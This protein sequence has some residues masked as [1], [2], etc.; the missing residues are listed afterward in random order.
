LAADVAPCDQPTTPVDPAD[1]AS[2]TFSLGD[3]W[4][5]SC[6]WLISANLQRMEGVHEAEVNFI[7]REAHV[8][9]DPSRVDPRR[10]LR[11]VRQLGYRAWLPGDKPYDEEEAHWFRLL[12]CSVLVMHDMLG[13]MTLY[14]RDWLGWSTPDQEWLVHIFNLMSLMASVPVILLLGIPILRAGIA[15]LLQRRAN[16]HA[17]I[18][19]GA[20]AAF[21]LS[22]RNIM[23]GHGRVY[24]DT[25]T[26]LLFL[27]AIGHWLEMRAQKQSNQAVERLFAELPQEATWI[28]AEGEQHLPLEQVSK[29]ARLRVRPGERF[30]VDGVVARGEGDVDESL[31]TGE[32]EPVAHRSG[33]RV[34]A[35]TINLDGAFEVITTATGAETVAGQVGRLLH[36]ALWQ[37][38]PIERLAD[39][40]AA[41]LT[42]IALLLAGA[43]FV[44][45]SARLG[46]ETGLI[47]ALS[48]LLIACPCALGIAT[49]LT[50]WVGLGRAAEAGAILRSTGVLEQL[51]RVQQVFF[52]KTGTL[53]TR[54]LRLQAVAAAN[55]DK[56]A[57][58]STV[59]ALEAPSEHPLAQAIL[60]GL[61]AHSEA[62]I[63][64]TPS[65]DRF[66]ALPGRGVTAWMD[67]VEIWAG[68]R[69]LM[70]EQRLT[71]PASLL[72]QAEQWQQQGQTLVYAGWE[73]RVQGML[74]LGEVVRSE[75][76]TA[77][78]QLQA[79]GVQV[80]ILTGD[81]AAAGKRWQ[82]LLGTPVLAEQR[83]EDKLA[84]LEAARSTA[85]VAMVGD[86][87]NDGPAL[88]AAS[89]GIAVGHSTD[90]AQAAA[91]VILL[92]DDLRSA[93][94]LLALGRAAMRKVHQNLVWAF[95]YNVI[96]VGLAMTGHLQPVISALFMVASSTL[97]MSNALR[98]RKFGQGRQELRAER[99]HPSPSSPLPHPT[100]PATLDFPH[101]VSD[102]FSSEMIAHG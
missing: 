42:P 64:T 60:A 30:P 5:P 19:L 29:G 35:G 68:S 20:F 98:L 55:L 41:W 63:R 33:D 6:S 70:A 25:T 4:C 14:L 83:P 75:V 86:G 13:S 45:W 97:V 80:T 50:L 102:L 58:L 85:S 95:A 92:N 37:R 21:A 9:F 10:L 47:N 96:G 77:L 78:H 44:F 89:V 34:L 3:L 53:T 100:P 38:A 84:R 11:R 65:L 51:A 99:E 27:V 36:Q 73:G 101:Q 54:P 62:S 56:T 57:F 91:D 26:V 23:A 1:A 8:R 2:A 18:A 24:F 71:F 61:D 49:P 39:R 69:Q 46:M 12:I 94:W 52:D 66:R 81:D 79:L 16:V 88:A 90:V 87:I 32:P 15:S 82:Q 72:D 43:T 31:L 22:L 17:F 67:G 76:V 48:V 28:T 59:G 93:P 40:L 7:Q 74:G